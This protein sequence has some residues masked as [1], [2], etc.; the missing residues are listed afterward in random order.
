M[1]IVWLSVVG[2]CNHHYC[3]LEDMPGHYFAGYTS[4]DFFVAIIIIAC[5]KICRDIILPAINNTLKD[6]LV[7][8][9]PM[10]YND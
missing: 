6:S 3:L 4:K 2:C 5:W 10:S 8:F 9:L 7:T 1:I